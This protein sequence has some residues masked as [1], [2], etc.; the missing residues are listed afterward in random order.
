MTDI[1]HRLGLP[2]LIAGQAQKEVWHNEALMQLDYLV[3]PVIL[4]HAPAI[5]PSNPQNGQSWIIGSSPSG[6]WSGKAKHLA[7]WTSQGWR[8]A[9]PFE[10]LSCWSVADSMI[11]RFDGTNWL[12]GIVTGQAVWLGGDQILT[13]RQPAI[14]NP[15]SGTVID[16]ESRVAIASILASLRVHGLIAS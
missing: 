10:G 7:C 16:A 14:N 11:W 13:S 9:A 2:F 12:K 3:Q 6:L 5:V 15:S 4:S 1:S 8:F